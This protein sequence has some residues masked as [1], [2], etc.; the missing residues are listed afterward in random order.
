MARLFASTL[1][2]ASA[3]AFAGCAIL[4]PVSDGLTLSVKSYDAGTGAYVVELRNNTKYPA[5]HDWP[6][7]SFQTEPSSDPNDY[8][9]PMVDGES[10]FTVQRRLNGHAVAVFTG[11]CTADVHCSATTSHAGVRACWGGGRYCEKSRPVW[12]DTPL[13]GR[14]E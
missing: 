5:L 11:L 14:V 10:I 1:A 2:A 12:T 4:P 6:F 9:G 7:L 13:N 3:L 8:V